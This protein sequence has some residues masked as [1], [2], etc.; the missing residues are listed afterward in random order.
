MPEEADRQGNMFLIMARVGKKKEA[1]IKE[2]TIEHQNLHLPRQPGLY[3]PVQRMHLQ[4]QQF[5]L[6]C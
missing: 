4:V 6:P 2:I 1:K 5:F 3:F